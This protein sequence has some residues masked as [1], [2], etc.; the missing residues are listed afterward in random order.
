MK[1]GSLGTDTGACL[2]LSPFAAGLN[3]PT[4]KTVSRFSSLLRERHTFFVDQVRL[5][6]IVEPEKDIDSPKETLTRWIIVGGLLDVFPA[7][8]RWVE[9]KAVMISGSWVSERFFCFDAVFLWASS[10]AT[11]RKLP[12]EEK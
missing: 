8:N 12:Q 6:G 11:C 9:M 1:M 4:R 2:A 3:R 7:D 10:D 5:T